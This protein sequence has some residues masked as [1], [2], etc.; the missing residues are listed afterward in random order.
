MEEIKEII[1]TKK[2]EE[3]FKKIRDRATQNR[4]EKQIKKIRLNP[5]F[6]KPLRYNLR[7]EWTIYV[8]PHRL[9]YKVEGDKLILL[10]F[11]HRK[12]VYG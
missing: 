10:R 1:W 9:I 7:G 2:F 5:N 6:G 3:D 11:E 8:K 4:L 12:Q